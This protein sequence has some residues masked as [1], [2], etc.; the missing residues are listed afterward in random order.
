MTAILLETAYAERAL[1]VST[2]QRRGA[3]GVNFLA[4]SN[5]EQD[6]ALVDT[7]SDI[8]TLDFAGTQ[9]S[10]SQPMQFPRVG[11]RP[12]ALTRLSVA[13]IELAMQ[14]AQSY[15]SAAPVA[16]VTS[17]DVRGSVTEETIAAI[18]VKYAAVPGLIV[19]GSLARFS[20]R[21]RDALQPLLASSVVVARGYGQGKAR[22]VS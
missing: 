10:P 16:E 17:S 3:A 15:K 8:D 11:T 6:N 19:S 4:L 14:R 22:R 9:A 20:D 21:V 5:P 18:T 7:A 1:A 2:A 12:D 13:N